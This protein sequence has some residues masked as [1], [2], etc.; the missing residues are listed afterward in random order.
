[1]APAEFFKNHSHHLGALLFRLLMNDFTLG[2]GRGVNYYEQVLSDQCYVNT[3]FNPVNFNDNT[4]RVSL[5]K[6][7]GVFTGFF[8]F[9]YI[10][11]IHLYMFI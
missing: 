11:N 9:F 1:M 7:G 4:Y 6:G 2:R 5:K 3:L 10:E 8:D